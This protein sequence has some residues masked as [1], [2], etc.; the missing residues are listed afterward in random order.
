LPVERQVVGVFAHQHMSHQDFCG[1]PPSIS[2]AC[3]GAWVTALSHARQPYLGRRS[4]SPELRRDHVE[5]LG[6]VLA[7]AVQRAAIAGTDLVVGLNDELIPR[8]V[9]RQ[10]TAI[11]TT[12][13]PAHRSLHRVGSH[14]GLGNRLFEVLK[15]ELQLIGI[16][17]FSECRPNRA[18]CSS[19][20]IARRC[21]FC[22][23]SLAAVAC[24]ARSSALSVATSS[25]S[26]TASAASGEELM[27]AVDHTAVLL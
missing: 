13:S 3:A 11:E 9:L 25:G 2:R 18:R 27:G 24:S 8:Q 14:L 10:S 7:D 20:T 1:Q 22:P 19:L 26:G 6:D 12:L 16:G 17:A 15:G 4:R 21:S 5:A 23:A